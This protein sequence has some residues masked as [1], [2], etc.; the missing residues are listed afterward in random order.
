MKQAYIFWHVRVESR[1]PNGIYQVLIGFRNDIWMPEKYFV[2]DQSECR[3]KESV[4]VL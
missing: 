4:V 3:I 2:L 1:T